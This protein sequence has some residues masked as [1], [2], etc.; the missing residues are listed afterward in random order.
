[1]AAFTQAI[2]ENDYVALTHPVTKTEGSGKWPVGTTGIVIIDYGEKKLV[3]ISNRG[4]IEDVIEV[5]ER[6]L[7]LATK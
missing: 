1:M 2:N 4:V 5:P 3:E 7:K 6:Q